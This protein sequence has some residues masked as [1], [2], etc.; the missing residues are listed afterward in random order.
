[1]HRIRVSRYLV[2]N[3]VPFLGRRVFMDLFRKLGNSFLTTDAGVKN[4]PRMNC[5]LI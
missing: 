4:I 5:S 1:M 2:A 3:Q